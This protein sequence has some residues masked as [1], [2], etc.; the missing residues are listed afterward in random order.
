M[1]QRHC[2]L[3]GAWIKLV[4]S[5]AAPGTAEK[6]AGNRG[7]GLD[8]SQYLRSRIESVARGLCVL[9]LVLRFLLGA[10]S[11]ARKPLR[12]PAWS[13][14]QA[15]AAGLGR[16]GRAQGGSQAEGPAL[17]T[18]R[19]AGPSGEGC[20]GLLAGKRLQKTQAGLLPG[21]MLASA[22]H[23]Q[24]PKPKWDWLCLDSSKAAYI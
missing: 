21:G 12:G 17:S 19:P 16:G 24:S 18:L 1:T 23:L 8:S 7:S 9:W 6:E 22:A 20:A 10:G 13:L 2:H 15:G 11:P 14:T 5:A 4:D 3:D